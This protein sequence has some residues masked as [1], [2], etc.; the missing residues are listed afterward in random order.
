[1]T[2]MIRGQFFGHTGK[3]DAAQGSPDNLVPLSHAMPINALARESPA[4]LPEEPDVRHLPW[5]RLRR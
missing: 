4:E 1:M 2:V 5:P 3:S